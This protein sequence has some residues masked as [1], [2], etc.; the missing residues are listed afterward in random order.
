MCRN[1]WRGGSFSSR[2]CCS[3]GSGL[4][5]DFAGRAGQEANWGGGRGG[6]GGGSR[7]GLKGGCPPAAINDPCLVYYCNVSC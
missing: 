5:R 7:D 2:V 3:V 6:R 4:K 1:Q